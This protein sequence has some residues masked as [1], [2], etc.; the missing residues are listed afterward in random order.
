MKIWTKQESTYKKHPIRRFYWSILFLCSSV[1][2][3]KSLALPIGFGILQGD[4]EYNQIIDED[5][6]I[7]HDQ[8]AKTEAKAVLNALKAARPV[9]GEWIGIEREKP[10]PVIMSAVTGNPSFA[11]FITDAI[12]LQTYGQG[13]RD[14]FWHEYT[15]IMMYQHYYNLFG[16]PG[17]L[18]HLPF[19]PAWFVEGLA[20]AFAVSVQSDVMA[21]IERYQALTGR[22]FTYDRLH[23]LYNNPKV[24]LPGYSISGAFVLW[25]F[26]NKSDKKLEK[27]LRDFK[28]YTRPWYWAYS[29]VPFVGFMP[30]DAALK[31]AVRLDGKELY[32]KYKKEVTKFW[33]KHSP[34]PLLAK[35]RERRLTFGSYRTLG[36]S[37]NKP[38]LIMSKKNNTTYRGNLEFDKKTSWVTTGPQKDKSSILYPKQSDS[39][40]IFQDDKKVYYFRKNSDFDSASN[41][42]DEY[43]LWVAVKKGKK[44]VN[45]KPIANTYLPSKLF[46]HGLSVT[47]AF[48][49]IDKSG[50]CTINL[51]EPKARQKCRT[52]STPNSLRYIGSKWSQ[53]GKVLKAFFADSEQ[54]LVGDRH[55]ILSVN[56]ESSRLQV[57]YLTPKP[58]LERP[59][60]YSQVGDK[61][62]F[63]V[64]KRSFRSLLNLNSLGACQKEIVFSDFIGKAVAHSTKDSETELVVALYESNRYSFKKI[65][66]TDAKTLK[67]C[68]PTNGHS[69]PL[70]ASMAKKSSFPEAI[71]A[72]DFRNPKL[73][74]RNQN[75]A[76][77]G[78][79][80]TS[81]SHGSVVA[82][83][84]LDADLSNQSTIGI[85]SSKRLDAKTLD[86]LQSST[87]SK[88][89]ESAP[90]EWHPRFVLM[91]PW[92]GAE[93][94]LGSQ[95]GLI[96]IPIMDHLQNETLQVT[97]LY[98]PESQFPSLDLTFTTTRYSSSYKASIYHAQT[99]N[100]AWLFSREQTSL[101]SSYYEESGLKVESGRLWAS[102]D[103]R[104]NFKYGSKFAN[105]KPFLGPTGVRQ[106]DL[107]EPFASISMSQAT[108]VGNLSLGLHGL[109]A[110]PGL[111]E[112][113]EYNQLGFSLG[114]S[115]FHR[116]LNSTTIL[117][118]S[119]SRTRGTKMKLLREVYTPLKTF[120]PGSGGGYNKN[121]FSISGNGG[122][123]SPRFGD[124]KSRLKF[125]WTMPVLSDIDKQL[126]L[127]YISRLDFT[128]F[129]NRGGAW[130]GDEAPELNRFSTA[131][132]YNLDLQFDNKG[133]NFNIGLGAGQVVEQDWQIYAT[134]GFDALF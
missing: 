104:F 97:A 133:V 112:E 120:V 30:M 85:T 131:H 39:L 1:I 29:L 41:L 8:R 15:H 115:N 12:E 68:T 89:V 34:G 126:W 55:Q 26:K 95:Y 37:G 36:F 53:E 74:H 103:T 58:I 57:N 108:W 82:S 56:L 109:A 72:S 107:V 99:W 50:F 21:S 75:S 119:A 42:Q 67:P 43:K 16:S 38:Y 127:V 90:Y 102:G 66:T 52:S 88:P 118:F 121:N 23:S 92:I 122:L 94:A 19:M 78:L 10:L 5:F 116:F 54:T 100:G 86:K 45:H 114:L 129:L 128:F 47:Y 83:N 14:L 124:T 46:K 73:W 2:A 117:G 98:G 44:F 80:N 13:D 20:E 132:G 76:E 111:N 106:G 64:G 70:L 84:S 31:D 65:D 32:E 22:W 62:W 91:F 6:Y 24:S 79:T 101:I 25:L 40:S 60:S 130:Y 51:R 87:E 3:Q 59:I 17:A 71:A 28:S 123:F 9:M 96:T 4:L 110:P 69:S 105:L 48:S 113:F 93:D 81:E 134:T 49:S 27:I 35:A 18:F 61:D 63:L 125:D 7:Y 11:N 77:N 33:Q